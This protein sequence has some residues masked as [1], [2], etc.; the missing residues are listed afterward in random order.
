MYA[1]E[2]EFGLKTFHLSQ[3]LN[4]SFVYVQLGYPYDKE[5]DEG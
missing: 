1:Q 5:K 2:G 3:D 4:S